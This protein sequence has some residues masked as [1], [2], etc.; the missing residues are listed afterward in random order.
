MHIISAYVVQSI[1]CNEQYKLQ[2]SFTRDLISI[3]C[4][5]Q[6][7]TVSLSV[8]EN[9]SPKFDRSDWH[10]I[11]HWRRRTPDTQMITI[12]QNIMSIFTISNTA[13]ISLS[14]IF[15]DP[16]FFWVNELKVHHAF[17]HHYFSSLIV[18]RLWQIDLPE[19]SR[20]IFFSRMTKNTCSI[21]N[22][23]NRSIYHCSSITSVRVMSWE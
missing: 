9:E 14:L 20:Y 16:L 15:A 12:W 18:L 19:T 11:L 4:K 10:D 6:V 8:T 22:S 2:N 23:S 1:G 17:S 3:L 13:R 7:Y 21:S 5:V